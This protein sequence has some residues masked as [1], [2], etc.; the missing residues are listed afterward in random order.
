MNNIQGESVQTIEQNT[1]EELPQDQMKANLQDLANKIDAKYQ[2]F[3]SQ[4]FATGNK[5]ELQKREALKE[6]FNIMGEAGIDLENPED[7]RLFLV[8]LKEK[9]PE[10]Y[11]I[12][13]SSLE[14]LFQEENNTNLPIETNENLPQNI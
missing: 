4:K 10:L 13:E 2:D 7:V 11:Q 1:G 6:V 8:S 3:N 9:N 5:I 14:E 12:V